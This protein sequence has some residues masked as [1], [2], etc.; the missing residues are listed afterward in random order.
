[1]IAAVLVT[2]NSEGFLPELLASIDRQTLKPDIRLALDDHSTD[3]TRDLLAQSGFTVIGAEGV[4]T[5]ITTRIAQNFVQ[6]VTAAQNMGAT[7]I[8]LGDHDDIWHPHRIAHQS[9]ILS[10]QDRVSFI[11][12]NGR[13]P[14]G[15]IRTT[16][17]V[18]ENFNE[19]DAREQWKYVAKHSIA[20]GGACAIAPDRLSTI[21]VPNG[22]LH[23]RWWSLRAVREHCMWIDSELVIDY[24][25]TPG[26]Q[27]GLD[28]AGQHSG[29]S[30]LWHKFRNLPTT[31]KKMKDIAT[32]LSETKAN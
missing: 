6:A 4:S 23:D 31:L 22:W 8:V 21:A 27:V 5:D 1:M 3:R 2:H 28:T 25:V 30:W 17:P 15:T 18:P 10:R 9:T 13:T 11:A 19:L 14:A 12:S 32:L 26:Q 16:F 24:R 20:T 29:L 7:Q